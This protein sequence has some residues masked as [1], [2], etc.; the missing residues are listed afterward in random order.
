LGRMLIGAHPV[1]DFAGHL[2]DRKL[3]PEQLQ[4]QLLKPMIADG[5]IDLCG[6]L[7]VRV[8]A[9]SSS[10]TSWLSRLSRLDGK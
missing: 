10:R 9:V 7:P 3:A 5:A 4:H 6:M 2:L 8:A 1:L